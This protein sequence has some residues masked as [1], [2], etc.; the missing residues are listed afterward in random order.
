M[1]KKYLI[2]PIRLFLYFLAILILSFYAFCLMISTNYGAKLITSYLFKD[3][4]QYQDIS[5]DPSLLGMRVDISNFLYKGAADFS[6]EDISLQINF[7]NSV[8]G[9]KIY[10]TEFSLSNAEVKLQENKQ[11]DG[12]SQ[13]EVFI[14][15]LSIKNLKVGKTVFKELS[16]SN[17]LTYKDAFGF[18]FQ[19]LNLD[20]SGNLKTIQGLNGKG[21]FYDGKLFG[22]LRA[23]ESALYFKFFEAPQILKNMKGNIYLDFNDK[24]K[25]PYANITASSEEKELKLTFKYADEFQLQMYTNGNEEVLFSYLTRSQK[26][27]KNFLRESNLKAEKLDILFS[28]SSLNDNLNF[29]SVILSETSQINIGDAE[30]KVNSL[31]TYVDNA[32]LKLFGDDFYVSEYSLGSMYLVNNFSSESMYELLLDETG[33]SVKFDDKGN[34]KSL[35]GDFSSR[36]NENFKLNLNEKDLMLNYKDIF[37]KFNYLDSYEFKNSVLKIYPKNFKSNFFSINEKE[38]NSFDFDLNNLSFRNINTEL[39]I[40]NQDENPLRNSNL[41]FNK[42][43]LGFNDAYMTIKEGNFDFGGLININGENISYSDTTFTIDALRV[44]SLIDI[45]SRLL[46]IL[47]ADFE[48]LDQ[49]NFYINTLDGEFFI[50][51]AGYAN[52]NKLKMKFDA[53][54]AELSGTIASDL[55]SFDNFNL[56]MIFNSTLSENI[57]WYV[58]ILGGLPA[59]ASAVVVTEVLEDGFS[60][61]TSSKYSIS[62]DVD[63]LDIKVIQ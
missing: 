28:I 10:V 16:L 30:F 20:L 26:E 51:S 15:N 34:F 42:L 49:R 60:G 27:I 31:K 7:L 6:G 52:I 55:E 35:Y 43:N 9:K 13:P 17:F 38:L 59:A 63:N 62:G 36:E 56:E 2:W 19:N 5:I 33:I 39:S 48:K 18:N 3:N 45:R 58:A 24:F 8:V 12:I 54:N 50:D 11:N 46:N 37:V 61:I 14:D 53:G 23:R 32:S 29:S 21:Y 41:R 44:L 57:P 1:V 25:I 22:D 40:R 47:N 4:I